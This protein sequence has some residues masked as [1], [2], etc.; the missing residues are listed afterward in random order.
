LNVTIK[1]WQL[2]LGCLSSLRAT[3]LQF[4][5]YLWGER[6][7]WDFK[8]IARALKQ[9]VAHRQCSLKVCCHNC[10]DSTKSLYISCLV[11][12]LSHPLCPHVYFL[13]TFLEFLI[14]TQCI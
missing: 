5:V 8:R 6:T 9:E 3:R 13:K 12:D 7:R 2:L 10:L 4:K 14:I 11:T 1:G